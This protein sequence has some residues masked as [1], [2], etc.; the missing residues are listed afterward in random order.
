MAARKWRCR[1]CS[2]S[3]AGIFLPINTKGCKSPDGHHDFY[4]V[5]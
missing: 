2:R 1:Y 5:D 4:W 3:G